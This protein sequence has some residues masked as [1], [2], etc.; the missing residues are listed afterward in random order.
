MKKHGT[1]LVKRALSVFLS[2]VLMLSSANLTALAESAPDEALQANA[3]FASG[4]SITKDGYYEERVFNGGGGYSVPCWRDMDLVSR[5]NLGNADYVRVTGSVTGRSELSRHEPDYSMQIHLRDDDHK[6][7]DI[8]NP[9]G[10]GVDF[11]Y[12]DA[13]SF[14]H[15]IWR[16]ANETWNYANAVVTA[17][18]PTPCMLYITGIYVGHSRYNMKIASYN[19]SQGQY[20]EMIYD[21]VEDGKPRALLDEK[22]ASAGLLVQYPKPCFTDANGNHVSEMTFSL[23]KTVSPSIWEGATA[24][25]QGVYA[26][27]SAVDF[28]GFRLLKPGTREESS[29]LLPASFT[30]NQTFLVKYAGFLS[31][32]GTFALL[33]VYAPKRM[34]ITFNND[35]AKV[36]AMWSRD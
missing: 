4:S 27:S 5:I 19:E 31:A 6:R 9:I 26:D 2:G 3:L 29:D 36:A 28:K 20:Q 7:R 16:D 34:R 13:Y 22:G 14:N 10:L 17:N 33:P 32:D 18:N 30:L 21:G 8:H 23:G 1:R 11:S 24:N 15:T 35:G 25:S 12:D